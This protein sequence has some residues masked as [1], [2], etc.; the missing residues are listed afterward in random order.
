MKKLLMA[1]GILASTSVVI[2]ACGG[3]DEV[4][5][6]QTPDTEEEVA[7]IE[8]KPEVAIA[9]VPLQKKAVGDEIND[10]VLSKYVKQFV[11]VSFNDADADKGYKISFDVSGV[12]QRE[13]GIYTVKVN[14]SFDTYSESHDAKVFVVD[15]PVIIVNEQE[16]IPTF[17]PE[18][19]MSTMIDYSHGLELTDSDGSNIDI[20]EAIKNE[21]IKV[22]ES[23]VRF[24]VPGIH[25]AKM[26]INT[27]DGGQ[28]TYY[29][30]VR[31]GKS[32][33]P[34]KDEFEQYF[35]FDNAGMSCKKDVEYPRN[36]LFPSK[37]LDGDVEVNTSKLK[38][39][40]CDFK[41]AT[42]DQRNY[43][44]KIDKLIIDEGH[45]SI[46]DGYFA[47]N[48]WDV[49][50]TKELPSIRNVYLPETLTHITGISI[51]SG[52][53]LKSIIIPSSV[54]VLDAT[55]LGMTNTAAWN[56][57]KVVMLGMPISANAASN[58]FPKGNTVSIFDRF[59]EWSSNNNGKVMYFHADF[60]FGI[61]KDPVKNARYQEVKNYAYL[62]NKLSNLGT[63]NNFNKMTLDN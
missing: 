19:A 15:G 25:I 58:I 9:N 22:D 60:D 18:I 54:S 5:T 4:E 21:K 38:Q 26:L 17:T 48:Q 36:L 51:F 11:T 16:D 24:S 39:W 29:R 62:T 42:T 20:N 57:K 63:F 52:T 3:K 49:G 6:P 33:T 43:F 2:T 28:Y 50:S 30:E 27:K 34:T 32:K 7:A 41:P 46:T 45:K 40:G 59:L 35:N 14:V 61:S 1:L 56:L 8:Y 53:A 47:L 44:R 12:N 37:Y 10:E 55:A 13:V 31:V 23:T